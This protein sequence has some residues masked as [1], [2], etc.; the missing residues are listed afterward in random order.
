MRL[1]RKIYLA[2]NTSAVMNQIKPHDD[3]PVG[4]AR[5][6][7]IPLIRAVAGKCLRITGHGPDRN[8]GHRLADMGLPVGVEIEVMFRQRSGAVVVSRGSARMAL[9]AEVAREMLVVPVEE[10]Q[11]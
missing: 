4:E 5:G 2:T 11:P 1:I 9:G 3:Q 10:D 7:G 8:T 6:D